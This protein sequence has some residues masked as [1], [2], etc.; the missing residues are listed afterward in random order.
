MATNQRPVF[1]CRPIT[2]IVNLDTANTS[3]AVVASPADSGSFRELYEC[4]TPEG[5]KITL[6]DFQFI[7]TGTS[8]A[9]ILNIWVTNSS[10]ANARVRKTFQFGLAPAAISTTYAGVNAEIP[11]LDFQVQNGQKVFVSVTTLAANTTLNV[12]ASIGEF[13]FVP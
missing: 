11:F 1:A 12:A 13:E 10:G 7:G 8:S 6:I 9:G 4:T 5:A 3:N 2:P